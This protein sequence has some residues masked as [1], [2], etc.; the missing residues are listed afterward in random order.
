LDLMISDFDGKT[1][2]HKQ[3]KHHIITVKHDDE[4]EKTK[5]PQL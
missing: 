2:S 5:P 3:Q 1:H 4:L